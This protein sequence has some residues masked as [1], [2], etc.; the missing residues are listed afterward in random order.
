MLLTCVPRCIRKTKYKQLIDNG[1]RKIDNS[2]DIRTLIETIRAVKLLKKLFLSKEQ[3][4][5]SKVT[6]LN[7]VGSESDLE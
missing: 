6:K 1:N 5:M 3:K 7:Y 2:L 4:T